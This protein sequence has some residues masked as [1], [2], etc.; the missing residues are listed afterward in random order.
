MKPLV[1]FL[2]VI[3]Y[4]HLSN[5]GMKKNCHKV[6]TD[7]SNS[8]Y[9]NRVPFV[10]TVIEPYKDFSSLKSRFFIS[11][12]EYNSSLNKINKVL[13]E[14][15]NGTLVEVEKMDLKTGQIFIE[16]LF[17]AN[18][19]LGQSKYEWINPDFEAVFTAARSNRKKVDSNDLNLPPLTDKEVQLL[20]QGY[21]TTY[22]GGL[23]KI[24]E[25]AYVRLHLQ[26]LEANPR[27]THIKYF[28]DK[29]PYFIEHIRKGLE[30]NYYPS[31][32]MGSKADQLKKLDKLEAESKKTITDEKVTY[33]WWLNFN[34]RLS[35]V[36]AGISTLNRIDIGGA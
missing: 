1:F 23:D 15:N 7:L 17:L 14:K 21:S 30:E 18:N 4:I 16:E 20:E 33:N 31:S 8:H 13:E 9:G 34:Y 10:D 19:L 35:A 26:R 11:N 28:S 32:S 5:A 3:F 22:T 36:M 6:F 27:I 29:I 2:Y 24:N 12:T 25:W